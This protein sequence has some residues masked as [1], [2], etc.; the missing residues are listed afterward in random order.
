MNADPSR[1]VY[2]IMESQCCKTI[3]VIVS[4]IFDTL[5]NLRSL[6][7]IMVIRSFTTIVK[8]AFSTV[9]KL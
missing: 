3:Y 7:K 5:N 6:N 9:P 4:D 2:C 8:I 1:D